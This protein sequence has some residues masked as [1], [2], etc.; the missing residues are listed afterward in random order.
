MMLRN[1][2]TYGALF[3]FIIAAII[4]LGVWYLGYLPVQGD[5]SYGGGW[6]QPAIERR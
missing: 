6:A 4:L 3:T 1:P 5:R 2:I